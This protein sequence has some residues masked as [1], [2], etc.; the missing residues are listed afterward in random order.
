[1]EPNIIAQKKLIVPIVIGARHRNGSISYY[2]QAVTPVIVSP[3]KK[4]VINLAPEFI[5]KQDGKTKEDSENAAVKRWL[6]RNPV[7]REK[8]QITLLLR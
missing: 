2:H 4:Q 1:M 6:L 5:K 3:V 8:N 7:E